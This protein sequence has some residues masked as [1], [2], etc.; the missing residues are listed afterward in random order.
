MQEVD[1]PDATLDLVQRFAR[2]LANGVWKSRVALDRMIS[3]AIQDY[4]YNRLAL[5]DKNLMRI[6]VYELE[7]IPYIPP[8]VTINEAIE[9]A[10][11]YS[12]TESGKFVNGVLGNVLKKSVKANFDQRN[13]PKDPD[14]DELERIYKAPVVEIEEVTVDADSEEGMAASR[15]GVWTNRAEG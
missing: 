13:A 5:I 3:A 1:Y 10:K 9:I 2:E 4:D 12:T 7:N 8:R 15:Y 6:A 11:R 14:F